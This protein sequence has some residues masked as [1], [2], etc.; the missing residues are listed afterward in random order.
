MAR[1]IIH[2]LQNMRRSAGFDIADHINTRYS[3]DERILKAILNFQDY[4]KQETLSDHLESSETD[5]S[6]YAEEHNMDGLV[7]RIGIDLAK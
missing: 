5:G 4:I 7:I 6:E 1:E 3:G 2:R